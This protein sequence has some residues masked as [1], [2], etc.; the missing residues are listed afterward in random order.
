MECRKG[1]W[2]W[3]GYVDEREDLRRKLSMAATCKDYEAELPE[4]EPLP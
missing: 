3:S 1:H 4:N 2:E